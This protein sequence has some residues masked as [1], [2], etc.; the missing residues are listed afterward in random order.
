MKPAA[1]LC[2]HRLRF[3]MARRA[4]CGLIA[5]VPLFVTDPYAARTSRAYRRTGWRSA[6]CCA[7]SS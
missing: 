7:C 1:N 6:A 3:D 5:L 4:I 2:Q